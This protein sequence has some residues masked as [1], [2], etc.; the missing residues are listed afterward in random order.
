MET[1]VNV[2]I[3]LLSLV[4]IIF[5]VTILKKAMDKSVDGTSVNVTAESLLLFLS[6]IELARLVLLK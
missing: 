6:V 3:G 4:S 5:C 2:L 1:I